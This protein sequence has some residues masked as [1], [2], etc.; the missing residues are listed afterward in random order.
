M[1]LSLT[2]NQSRW[3]AELRSGKYK[4]GTGALQ[5]GDEFCCLG[6]AA[7]MFATGATRVTLAPL[8]PIIRPELKLVSYNGC[9]ASAPLYVVEALGLRGNCGE[10]V[11]CPSLS[12][13]ND[14]SKSF[15]R[16]ADIIE[17]DPERYFKCPS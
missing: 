17:S 7:K 1:T 15:S 5:C 2:D 9:T 4:Q 12:S 8:A 3:L 14:N 10:G 13:L 16:I 11:A 6:V